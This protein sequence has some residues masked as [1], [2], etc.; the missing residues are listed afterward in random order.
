MAAFVDWH[1][2]ILSKVLTVL[3]S[4]TS[5]S[6]IDFVLSGIYESSGALD[7]GLDIFLELKFSR[8]AGD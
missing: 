3:G 6:I 4:V 2:A 8:G 1:P 5:P 7:E